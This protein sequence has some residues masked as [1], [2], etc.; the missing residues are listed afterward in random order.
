MKKLLTLLLIPFSVFSQWHANNGD[1]TGSGTMQDPFGYQY[2]FSGA[3]GKIQGGD[4]VMLQD[5]IYGYAKASVKFTDY[6]T[7]MGGTFLSS[8]E[9]DSENS[10]LIDVRGGENYRFYKMSLIGGNPFRDQRYPGYSGSASGFA[11]NV[12]NNIQIIDCL[13]KNITANGVYKA[14]SC[15]NVL[16]K[17]NLIIYPSVYSTSTGR[18]TNHGLYIQ[19]QQGST[20]VIEGNIILHSSQY[21]VQ[22]WHQETGNEDLGESYT[23][24]HSVK[25]VNNF[26]VGANQVAI[27]YGGYNFGFDGE[28]VCN[29]IYNNWGQRGIRMGYTQ[30]SNTNYNSRFRIDSNLVMGNLHVVNPRGNDNSITGNKIIDDSYPFMIYWFWNDDILSAVQGNEIYTN[31]T[32]PY[33]FIKDAWTEEVGNYNEIN[34]RDTDQQAKIRGIGTSNKA[35]SLKEAV[36]EIRVLQIG[37]THYYAL[38]NPEMRDFFTIDLSMFESVQVVDLENPKEIIYEGDGKKIEIDMLL[39]DIEPVYGNLP[40]PPKTGKDFGVYVV[41]ATGAKAEDQGNPGDSV[42]VVTPTYNFDSAFNVIN[43]K[44]LNLEKQILINRDSIRNH[45]IEI[46]D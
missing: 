23:K 33:Q 26:F 13:I 6:V 17:N 37:D 11:L 22:V 32:R 46:I 3:E 38:I 2:A 35:L 5:E 39:T 9:G 27:Q 12:G 16:I 28:I 21:G 36:N 15:R 44:I 8:P 31:D 41:N 30:Q 42:I 7:F 24:M 10:G 19:N 25:I 40:Q 29:V 4:T 43:Q 34:V 20:C 1:H 45:K 14:S 18:L